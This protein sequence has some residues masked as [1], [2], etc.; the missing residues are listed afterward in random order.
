MTLT[1]MLACAGGMS[2]SLLVTRM[3]NAAAKRNLQTKIFARGIGAVV[4]ESKHQHL[5][6]V[7]IGPQVRYLVDQ[8]KLQIDVPLAVIPMRA[9]GTM[10]GE[11]VLDLALK[12][13]RGNTY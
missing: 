5:D 6:V 2:S 1:I 11:A 12:L 4:A 13:I 9:Y 8:V 7:L 10:D 3:Q